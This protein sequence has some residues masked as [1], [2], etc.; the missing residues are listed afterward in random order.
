MKQ[1]SKRLRFTL[2]TFQLHMHTEMSNPMLPVTVCSCSYLRIIIKTNYQFKH[3]N[4]FPTIFTYYKKNVSRHA[5]TFN[6]Q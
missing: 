1:V 3:T 6:F 5:L 2:N 4:N